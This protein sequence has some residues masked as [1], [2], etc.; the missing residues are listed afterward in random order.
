[1]HVNNDLMIALPVLVF[2]NT[3]STGTKSLMTHIHVHD[4]YN[5][6]VLYFAVT[7]VVDIGTEVTAEPGVTATGNL[8]LHVSC[9]LDHFDYQ[10][11]RCFSD[12]AT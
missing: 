10:V 6:Y 8:L 11:G 3:L 9:V 1:M 4:A 5:N 2:T 12:V 7:E